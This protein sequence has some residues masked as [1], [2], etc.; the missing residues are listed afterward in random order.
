MP[1]PRPRVIV[2]RR[3]PEPVET[4][5]VAEFDAVINTGPPF[6][7]AELAE[8]VR[9]CDVIACTVT[10]RL[11]AEMLAGAGE[12]LKLLANFG[13]GVDHIDV[14]AAGARGILVSNTPDVLTDD[15]ADVTLALIL[16]T[17]RGLGG[18]ERLVRSGGWGGWGPTRQMGRS[19]A[20]K[21]LAIV[22]MGRIGLA[23]AARARACGM[24]IHYHNRA[25]APQAEA[26]G[27]R[28]WP[29]LDA[30]IAAADVVSLSCPY[31]AQTHHLI[32]A[33]RL[34]LMKR[35]A[36]LINAARGAIVDQEALIAALETGA[37]A[38]AGLDVYPE[39][40]HVDPRL[41]ALDNVMLLPHLGS[42]T[43]ETRIAMGE[44]VLANIRAWARG[45]DLPNPV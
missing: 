9:S 27:A 8:A 17:M 15:T 12:R 41:I 45:E 26:A 4:R 2:T 36:F 31:S 6:T 39:E 3:L 23:V 13:V 42:A 30:M 14:A 24:A 21:A 16:G 33:R 29:D 38:G 37:I 40:P 22:G 28:F 25:P 7:R 34:S 19:L 43:V 10:D 18:G 1:D 35:D 11:D 5:L 32:D 44:R 20:G